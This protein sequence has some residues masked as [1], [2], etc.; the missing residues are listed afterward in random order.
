MLVAIALVAATT[1]AIR[2]AVKVL[3]FNY[4]YVFSLSCIECV[5]ATNA[6]N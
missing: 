5:S 3:V 2:A 4:G 6:L 1:I